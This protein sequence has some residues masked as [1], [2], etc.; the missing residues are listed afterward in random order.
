MDET[1]NEVGEDLVALGLQLGFEVMLGAI[2]YL[3]LTVERYYLGLMIFL[4]TLELR[5]V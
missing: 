4:T 2:V 1:R 3:D 5:Y